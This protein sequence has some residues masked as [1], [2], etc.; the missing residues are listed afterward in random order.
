MTFIYAMASALSLLKHRVATGAPR[1]PS[2]ARLVVRWRGGGQ[3][4]SSDP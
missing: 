3:S 4:A 1:R 2:Q